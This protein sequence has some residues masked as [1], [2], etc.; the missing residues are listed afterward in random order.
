MR[1][2]S[3]ILQPDE[4]ELWSEIAERDLSAQLS[5][6]SGMKLPKT[7]IEWDIKN[8]ALNKHQK[9]VMLD[10]LDNA[11][12]GPFP[13]ANDSSEIITRP[14]NHVSMSSSLDISQDTTCTKFN[15]HSL[16]TC[17]SFP[18]N[19][20]LDLDTKHIQVSSSLDSLESELQSSQAGH[21]DIP[22][23]PLTRLTQACQNVEIMNILQ[24]LVE[25]P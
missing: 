9:D 13:Q 7:F 23:G 15:S 2:W 10:Q 18:Q 4:K 1:I 3:Q 11:P 24:G 12:S 5:L 22:H 6:Q 16:D 14:V 20:H 21:S 17:E 8:F 25:T 19:T